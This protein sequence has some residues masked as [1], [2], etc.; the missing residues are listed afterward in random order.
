M[1]LKYK[2]LTLCFGVLFLGSLKAD[3]FEWDFSKGINPLNSKMKFTISEKFSEIKDGF[4]WQTAVGKT[5]SGGIFAQQKYL[6]LTPPEAFK[7]SFEI[8]FEAARSQEIFLFLWDSK[9]DYLGDKTTKA[10]KNSG[11]TIALYR[12]KNSKTVTPRAWL[13]F[14][15]S[16]FAVSGKPFV[17]VKGKKY[18]LEFCYNGTGLASFYID[19][20]LNKEVNVTPGGSIA[21]ALYK[22]AIGNRTVGNYFGFD[23]KIYSVKLT[24]QKAELLT[25][26]AINR[27]VFLRGEKNAFLKVEIRNVSSKEIYG[28]KAGEKKIVTVPVE[29][30]LTIGDYKKEYSF[31]GQKYFIPYTVAPKIHE[32]MPILMWG[33]DDSFLVLKKSGFTHMLNSYAG[34]QFLRPKENHQEKMIF[35]LD[36]MY[37]HGFYFA[38][39]FTLPHYPIVNKKYPRVNKE[40]KP[41]I[42]GRKM[43][44]D[45]QNPQVQ[46]EMQ[47]WA[48]KIAA[49]YDRHPALQIL[50]ICSEIRDWSMPSFTKYER[51]A[52]LKDTKADIPEKVNERTIHYSLIPNFPATRVIPETNPYLVYYRWFWTKGDGWNPLFSIISDSYRK[53]LPS[54]FKSY[55]APAVRQPPCRA[56]GGNANFL[57]HWSYSNPEPQVLAATTDELLATAN[58]KPVVQGTQ[59]ILYRNASAPK[60]V[61]VAYPPAWLTKEKDANYITNPPD[62][63]IQ[64]IWA[65]L[66]R[67]VY[68][69][70]FHGDGSFYPPPVK[71]AKIYRC[72]NEKSE[73][74]FKK[75]MNE[76]VQ[77]LGPA[78]MNVK[79]KKSQVA[80]LHSFT[81][82]VLAQ[83]GSFG[84][85]SWLSDLHIALQTAALD[86]YVI[87]EED[88][89]DGKIDNVK[90]LFLSHCDV[91]T[92]SVYKKIIEFQLR[93]GIIV[94]DEFTPPAILPN[95][96]FR[97]LTRTR[98]VLQSKKNL[99]ALGES[100]R[101]Q[102]GKYY[103]P[104]SETSSP[105]LISH[106]RDNY[107]FVINDKRTFGNYIGQWKRFAEKALPNKG[108]VTVN[109]KSGAVY[110][111]VKQCMVPFKIVKGKTEINVDFEG[112]GGKLFLLLDSP[113]K[114]FTL[115]V[116][117]NGEIIA[118]CKTNSVIPVQLIVRDSNGKET[119]DTH[120][121]F[122]KNG[123]FS[124]KINI[125]PN[126]AKGK[127][128]IVLK[129]LPNQLEV[130]GQLIVK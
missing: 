74:A 123:V 114:P 50:D 69:M 59:L 1:K 38:D 84:W 6:E 2:I 119:D 63:L 122:A 47:Q 79:G 127:W 39:Y 15:R 60:N 55:F 121:N 87:F 115:T 43:S 35:E 95:L 76:V 73:P 68:G 106:L 27:K 92:E 120:Y 88:I 93:G 46:K 110:D 22:V 48:E 86:P 41:Y 130:K 3:V 37:K 125:P 21:P 29:T 113:L 19:G 96:R 104:Q 57:G 98:D 116:K 77:P 5:N 30:N 13:G 24:T 103:V 80:I 18:L 61:K 72:T 33:F 9:G 128:S 102:L 112:A 34:P 56:V 85:N 25:V 97:T 40:G 90:V 94:A 101:K 28:L 70:V 89:L 31:S 51:N 124:Y 10:L 42:K 105:D 117:P 91:L 62:T 78:L 58:G 100:F 26:K 45:V 44:L 8:S 66:S 81:S 12:P 71:G 107:L 109:Q 32:K 64:S 4:L 36:Q 111:L 11:F 7:I 126:A 16:T 52:C 67:P 23:G 49:T 54:T 20:K 14:G 108:T 75:L 53:H 17:P 129:S 83:R 65:T 99:V 118:Q 82:S